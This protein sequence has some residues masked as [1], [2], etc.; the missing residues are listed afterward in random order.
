MDGGSRGFTVFNKDGTLVYES[1]SAF[2]HALVE[3]GHYP[4]RRSDAKGVEPEG[5]EVATF[6]NTPFMFL[7]AERGSVVG[8]YDMSAP[9]MPK[10]KQI[11]PSGIS[12]EGAISV[13]ARIYF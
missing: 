8:V 11:L 7:R 5:M 13:P 1:N 9:A 4:D 10:L 6:G 2:E 3:V 12:P